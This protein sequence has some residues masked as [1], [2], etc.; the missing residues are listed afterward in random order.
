MIETYEHI[1]KMFPCFENIFE[2]IANTF[3]TNKLWANKIPA[4][5]FLNE[6]EIGFG[7]KFLL[8]MIWGRIKTNFEY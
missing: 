6:L 1:A 8:E 7:N 4:L 3:I 2:K 5:N